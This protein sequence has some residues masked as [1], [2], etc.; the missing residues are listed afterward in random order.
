MCIQAS[1]DLGNEDITVYANSSK[2]E[3]KKRKVY[4]K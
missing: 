1:L 3:K 2:K 4:A